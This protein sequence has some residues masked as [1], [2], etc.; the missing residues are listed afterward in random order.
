MA[1][2]LP[3]VTAPKVHTTGAAAISSSMSKERTTYQFDISRDFFISV[4]LVARSRS[5]VEPTPGN[6]TRN[7]FHEESLMYAGGGKMME[8]RDEMNALNF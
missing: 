5:A 4:V 1:V 2:A 6:I 7:C 8:G 3:I